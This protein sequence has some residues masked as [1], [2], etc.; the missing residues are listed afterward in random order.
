MQ[1]KVWQKEE[2]EGC[3]VDGCIFIL[4]HLIRPGV[5]MRGKGAIQ[6]SLLSRRKHCLED[7][8]LRIIRSASSKLTPNL[9]ELMLPSKVKLGP[10]WVE[11]CWD[12]TEGTTGRRGREAE[13]R[14]EFPMP[15][16]RVLCVDSMVKIK[17]H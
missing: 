5:V 1:K 11:T 10:Y 2:I 12:R 8:P 7:V 9:N 6:W 4:F 14:G 17:N 13:R 3:V 16:G 15:I